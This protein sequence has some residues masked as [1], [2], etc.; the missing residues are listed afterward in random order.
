MSN[1]ALFPVI[2][3]GGAGERLWPVSREACPKPFMHLPDGESLMQKT[4]LRAAALPQVEEIVTVTNREL[5]FLTRDEYAEVTPSANVAKRFI[6]EPMG[7]N[8]APAI[9]AAALQLRAVYGDDA[10]MLVLAADHLIAN[11]PAF[12][13]AVAEAS[14]LAQQGHLVTFGI[15]PNSPETG[16]G[17]IERESALIEGSASGYKAARFVEKP[18]LATAQAYIASGKFLWNSGMFCFTAGKFLAELAIHAP[19]VLHSADA[20]VTKAVT[21]E[22]NGSMVHELL[23]SEFAQSPNISVDYAVMENANNVATVACDIGWNDIGSWGALGDLLT[24]DAD[25]NRVN[26]TAFFHDTKDCTIH[27]DGRIVGA[28]GVEN[29][30]LVDT[31]DALLIAHKDRAQDVK[32]IV[33]QLKAQNHEAYKLHRTV[34]RPWGTYTVLEEGN[35]FKI[36][37]IVVKAGGTLSMQMHHHRSEHWIIVA[38]TAKVTNGEEVKLV[39][40]NE[41]TYIPA[42]HRHRLENPG[43]IDL[44]MIEVQSGSYLG[45]DDI[46]RF[47]DKYGRAPATEAKTTDAKSGEKAA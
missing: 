29:L 33:K 8:T 27:A 1:N 20:A 19:E 23:A 37:R 25:G 10:I 30:I 45:E 22:Q 18:D 38:G 15:Q 47:E 24:P 46:V 21:T 26:G 40:T 28:V 34:H 43:K 11:E 7:R 16:F 32:Q 17:Y 44:V 31:P 2:I 35:G 9:A 36:K 14:K 42:G 3:A 6:L 12:A 13:A 4:Y 39:Y 41:S 5:F